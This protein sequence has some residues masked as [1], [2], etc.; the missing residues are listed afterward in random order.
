MPYGDIRPTMVTDGPV[1]IYGG[2]YC[3]TKACI[4]DSQKLWTITLQ[5]ATSQT[6]NTTNQ[7]DSG[8]TA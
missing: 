2:I 3:S 5:S 6:E 4:E 1:N 8:A 7:I